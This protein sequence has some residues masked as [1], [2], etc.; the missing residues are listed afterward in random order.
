MSSQLHE[1]YFL[2]ESQL[3]LGNKTIINSNNDNDDDDDDDDYNND[4]VILS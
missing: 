2:C 1:D 4:S 3:C